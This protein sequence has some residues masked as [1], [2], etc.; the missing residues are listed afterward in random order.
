MCVQWAVTGVD[1]VTHRQVEDSESAYSEVKGQLELARSEKSSFHEQGEI[2]NV[3]V[4]VCVWHACVSVHSTRV[5]RPY[6]NSLS[7]TLSCCSGDPPQ[8][9]GGVEGRPPGH[10][11]SAIPRGLTARPHQ[12]GVFSLLLELCMYR[13]LTTVCVCGGGGVRVCVCMWVCVGVL[14]DSCDSQEYLEARQLAE[15]QAGQM[16]NEVCQLIILK[17][18]VVEHVPQCEC[19]RTRS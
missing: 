8:R 12:G 5:C 1:G 15:A 3:C 18:N 14:C 4:C 13:E 7:H 11:E 9:T 2:V 17:A 10:K 16:M 19:C 6:G